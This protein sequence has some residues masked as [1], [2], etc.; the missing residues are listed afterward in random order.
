MKH[1]M[2]KNQ[3]KTKYYGILSLVRLTYPHV[4]N[5]IV[6]NYI[7]LS[8][9]FWQHINGEPL[10]VAYFLRANGGKHEGKVMQNMQGR[11]WI[12]STFQ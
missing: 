8:L 5:I 9:I 4:P 3:W 1:D 10:D 6:V 12:E 7:L 11:W 2:L